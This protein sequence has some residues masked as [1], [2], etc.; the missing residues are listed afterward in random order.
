MK[1]LLFAVLAFAGALTAWSITAAADTTAAADFVVKNES[2][3]TIVGLYIVPHGQKF[4]SNE[5]WMLSPLSD[6][7]SAQLHFFEITPGPHY[8]A[9][10]VYAD[11]SSSTWPFINLA[12]LNELRA[13]VGDDGAPALSLNEKDSGDL[14]LF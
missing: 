3:R 12:T 8:D 2:H 10:V 9:T 6:G 7:K 11:R 13:Y 5:N 1:K 14:S 4:R